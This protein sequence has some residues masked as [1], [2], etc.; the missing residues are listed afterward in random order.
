[1]AFSERFTQDGGSI[2]DPSDRG[3]FDPGQPAHFATRV[4]RAKALTADVIYFAGSNIGAAA[5]LRRQMLGRGLPV[6][7]IGPHQ[8]ANGQ[9]ARLAGGSAGG[10][11]YPLVGPPP[12]P[13]RPAATFPRDYRRGYH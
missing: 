12:A 5:T 7:L 10:R 2:V 3:A 9:F 6:P 11:Y 13:I 1:P 8:L 4:D